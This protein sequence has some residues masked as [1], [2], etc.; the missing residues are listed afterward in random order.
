M[1]AALAGLLL[2]ACAPA[3]PPPTPLRFGM[4][5]WPGYFP[6]VIAEREGGMARRGVALTVEPVRDT[7]TLLADFAAGR[8]DLIG[9][10]L[11]DAITLGLSRPDLVVLLV[12]DESTGGDMLLRAPGAMAA[13]DG[14]GP[15]RVGTN[16]GGFGELFVRKWLTQHGIAPIRVAWTD[17]DASEIPAALAEGRIDYGHTWQPHAAQA[18]AQGATPVFSSAETPGLI[19]D[20]VLTTRATVAR[21]PEALRAFSEAWFEAAERWQADPASGNALATTALGL[22]ASAASLEGIALFGLAE[23]RRVMAG[24]EAA[25]LALLIRR[26]SD[27][28]VESGAI[29]VPPTATAMFDPHLLP[30]Q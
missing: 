7:S 1:V 23:N 29:S 3:P 25:P 12:A 9:V 21:K 27:F 4:D 19:L 11:G 14:V 24:G 28:F 22:P 18:I 26:Y 5:V 15:L 10:S 13:A 8:Y 30:A 16:L 2:A 20:V 6:A 17:V